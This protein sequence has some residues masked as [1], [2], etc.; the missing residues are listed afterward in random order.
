MC[1]ALILPKFLQF[2]FDLT[3]LG[4][5]CSLVFGLSL[6]LTVRNLVKF[7][8]MQA[9]LVLLT[10]LVL[11]VLVNPIFVHFVFFLCFVP[12]NCLCSFDCWL[13]LLFL[14]SAINF[15]FV[16]FSNFLAS[17]CYSKVLILIIYKGYQHSSTTQ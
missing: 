8:L 4:R 15:L 6:R 10:A 12:Y 16:A 7:L 17:V 3:S 1:S 9:H 13:F 14:Q 11:N 5:I 2:L